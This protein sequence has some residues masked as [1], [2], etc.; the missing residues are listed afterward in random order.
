[1]RTSR[2]RADGAD[3]LILPGARPAIPGP[4]QSI[5]DMLDAVA[6]R[7]RTAVIGR[8][9]RIT[10]DELDRDANRVAHVLRDLGVGPGDR[11]GASLPNDI[12]IVVAFLGAMRIG[13]VW[14]GIPR[15]FAPG[16]KAFLASDTGMSVLLADREIASEL[17]ARRTEFDAAVELVTV[18]DAD[19]AARLSA[20]DVR[21]PNVEIDPFA[22]AAISYTS[23]T[24]GRPKGVVHSQH[25]LLVPGAVAVANGEFPPDGPIATSAPMTIL[26]LFVLVPLTAFQAGAACVI[27]DSND[28]VRVADWIEREAI[29][30]LT[31]VP[32]VYHD[33][34]SEP[35]VT[36]EQLAPLLRARSG[37]AAVTE[38]L[39]SRWLD[40]F[41]RRLT[42][43]LSMTEAPTYVARED[44]DEERIEGSL[45]RAV[46]HVTITIVDADD[47]PVPTGEV[48]EICVAPATQGEWA[49]VYTPMYGYWGLADETSRALRGGMLHTGDVGRL[50][51][52]G[53]LYL[54]DRKS[55][56]I[57]RGGSNIYPAEV[58]NVLLR[59]ARVEECVLVPRPDER[60]GETTVAF[61]RLAP[62]A[63]VDDVALRAACTEHLARYKVPDEIRVVDQFPRTALGKPNRSAL[64]RALRDETAATTPT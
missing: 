10:Y 60:L 34:I 41:G 42:S 6:D 13:A 46:D 64:A 8:S 43:S 37:G 48:G 22:P 52:R 56:L 7:A 59:D 33:L 23:G 1:M 27:I 36:R 25:N 3:A 57:I 44:P 24:T 50:D 45:G 58:E 61:V 15:A 5:A 11:V 39:R 14:V 40:K 21:R 30:H 16:E 20:A 54:V 31:V 9:G 18:G 17:D 51:D 35:S 4:V 47:R 53:N 38:S 26:N 28:P 29:M 62:G 49:G 12:D 63:V 2:E 55:S 19:W 32:T